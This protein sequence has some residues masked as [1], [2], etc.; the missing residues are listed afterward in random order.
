MGRT[1]LADAFASEAAAAG[2]TVL[3]V[4]GLPSSPPFALVREFAAAL[5]ALLEPSTATASLR[6]TVAGAPVTADLAAL[7]RRSARDRALLVVVDDLDLADAESRSFFSALLPLLLTPA[8]AQPSDERG[9]GGLLLFVTDEGGELA[10]AESVV[11]KPL[12]LASLRQWLAAE[13]A[14][15]ALTLT[16]GLPARMHALLGSEGAIDFAERRLARLP[17]ADRE[18]L[19]AVAL[20]G[21]EAD[22]E[23]VRTVAGR[24]DVE[25]RLKALVTA[26]LASAVP[27]VGR[28]LYGLARPADTDLL[29]G[30]AGATAVQRLRLA[31]AELLAARGDRA[32]AFGHFVV[33][34]DGRAV[35]A[36]LAAAREAVDAAAFETACDLLDRLLPLTHGADKAAGLLLLADAEERRGR[37]RDALRALGRAKGLVAFLDRDA[38][39]ARCARLCVALGATAAAARLAQRVRS[40]PA[41]S[42]EALADALVALTEARFLRGAY[43]EVLVLCAEAAPTTHARL[44]GNTRGKAL[45]T[46]GRLD[47]ARAQFEANARL[48]AE[49]DDRP[50][51]ARALLNLG[52]VAH[53]QGDRAEARSR[54]R[55]ALGA[56]VPALEAIAHA[57]LSSLALEEGDA[58]DALVH[59]HHALGRFAAAGRLKEQAHAAQNLARVYLYLGDDARAADVARH[60]DALASRVGDPYVAAGARLVHAEVALARGAADATTFGRCAESFRALKNP[61]YERESWLLA[62]EAAMVSG[63]LDDAAVALAE[64]RRSGAA[65]QAPL[66]AEFA[67]LEAE[68]A[69]ATADLEGAES[70]LATAG[71]ALLS[72][73]DLELPARWH[74]LKGALAA[75]RGLEAQAS[76]ERLRAARLVEELA[77][78]LA[79]DARPAFLARRRRRAVL[80]A[81]GHALREPRPSETAALTPSRAE[82]I[83]GESPAIRRLH[84]LIARIGPSDATVLV[85]GESGTGKELVARA[86][87]EASPRRAM[88]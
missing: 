20:L 24:R 81:A 49:A 57:N 54:Y 1:T 67:L 22:P 17:A 58:S 12:D 11:V 16:G 55:E 85:R 71:D 61:R 37:V 84:E 46:L 9:Q 70:S 8:A 39:R 2:T 75:A 60:S 78:R 44:L 42:P 68:L 53:R 36:G 23:A 45:L 86:L 65:G 88:P 6:P 48:C 27:A 64:A 51:G 43:E 52:V 14:E 66:A 4:R 21:R 62:V 38:L 13:G 76:I 18:L 73:P 34:A 77:A 7:V 33:L 83:V 26:R 29:E 40:E 41:A 69:L 47:E 30:L 25:A 15:R 19:L 72:Y 59:A 32:A 63:V 3:Q 79:P 82:A 5:N 10:G 56:R 74:F 87:H 28:T 80:E 31:A 50:E 35:G